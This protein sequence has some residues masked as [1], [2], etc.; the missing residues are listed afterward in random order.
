MVSLYKVIEGDQGDDVLL[1][2]L[3]AAL[4]ERTKLVCLSHIASPDGRLLP[5]KEAARIAHDWG[6]PIVLDTAQSVGQMPVDISALDCDFVVGSGHKWLLGP[7][8]TGYLIVSANQ[9]PNFRPN[10]IADRSPWTLA[11]AATP[12]ATARPR[13]EIGTYNH[14]L[15][16]GLG[17]AVDIA[18]TIGLDT[19]QAKVLA[20]THTLR[21]EVAQMDRVRIITPLEAGKSAGI[22]SLMF[23]GFTKTEMDNLVERLH[24]RQK[25][26]V[27]AQ[28]L[29]APPDPVQVAMRISVAA[30]NS[31]DEVTRLLDGLE[32]GLK[33]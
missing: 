8:G 6:T 19:I 30:F 31:E 28:W 18:A 12:P 25:V 4:T 26:V 16:V 14:A 13:I 15:V 3:T 22:T 10:F 21:S 29:R 17:R 32:E 23:D 2:R 33:N 7:M 24:T 20:L 1:E 5:V 11:G 27:K 9:I